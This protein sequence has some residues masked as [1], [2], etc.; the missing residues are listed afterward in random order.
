[1]KKYYFAAILS[2][3]LIAGCGSKGTDKLQAFSGEAFAYDLGDGWDVN[4]SVRVKGFSQKEANSS[5]T[6]NITYTVDLITPTGEKKAKLYTGT[7]NQDSK[8]KLADIPLEAQFELDSTY[9]AGE[10][11]VVFNISDEL[12]NQKIS[13][14]KRLEL[15][16]D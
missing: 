16:N 14:E 3:L 11:K 12:G 5:F 9:T 15:E 6:S 10:Y 4:A 8:E 2:I 1:M 13:I 7:A